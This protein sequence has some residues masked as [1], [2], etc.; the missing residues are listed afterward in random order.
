MTFHLADGVRVGESSKR[1]SIC[2]QWATL[3]CLAQ[4]EEAVSKGPRFIN[5]QAVAQRWP[6]G[7][8]QEA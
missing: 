8:L 5:R 3:R 6:F 2:R 4:H 1:R 7:C